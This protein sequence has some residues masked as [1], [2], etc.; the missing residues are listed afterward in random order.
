MDEIKIAKLKKHKISLYWL[1]PIIALIITILL[2]WENS[3]NKGPLILLHMEDAS[4]IE[5]GKTVVKFRSVDVGIVESVNLSDDYSGAV[6]KIR[7]YSDT[8]ELLNED[9]LFWIEKPR[10][11]SH[12]ITGL[13]TIL[14]GC[15]IQIYK[16]KSDKYS[17][18]FVSLKDVP[19]GLNE[20]GIPIKLYGHTTAVI[21]NG[22]QINYKGF[23]IGIIV[24]SSYDIDNDDVVY[25][26][27][28][29]KPYAKLVN[30]N[31][32][33]WV[34]SGVDFSL[35]PSGF[36]FNVPNLENVISGS[37]N[38]YQFSEN[39]GNPLKPNDSFD[40]YKDKI[41][42]K[43]ENLKHNPKYVVLIDDDIK[44]IKVGSKVNFRGLDIG[45][46][47]KMPWYKNDS[48]VFDYKN[49]IPVLIVLDTDKESSLKAEKVFSKNLKDNTLCAQIDNASLITPGNVIKLSIDP[50]NKCRTS[51][52]TYRDVAVIP[53]IK[54]TDMVSEM[55]T[56][57]KK[58]NTLDLKGI[59]NNLNLALLSLDNTL[60][61]V[62]GVTD[63]V[64]SNHTLENLNKVL[65]SYN[66]N[67]D[68]YKSLLDVSNKLNQSLNELNPTIKKVGQKSNSLVFSSQEKDI[69]PKVS[70]R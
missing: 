5:A 32:V 33:F 16:G 30:S 54:K 41:T 59:T 19:L 31:S 9:S 60:K 34:D 49:R 68:L 64:N 65:D 36:N 29:R 39:K 69:E 18:E 28:I 10:I 13:E 2:V 26:A 37:I 67:S 58:L 70:K 6:A 22:S 38:V 21:P 63:S 61:S 20:N 14:S 43:Y 17:T 35:T 47:I 44:N 40:V 42:A 11:Q 50:H 46:V 52:S 24:S 1:V 45:Q 12:S 53:L 51:N 3:F 4:G 48:E 15:Y 27:L 55:Q 25:N 62:K 8:S 7:M 23:N 66:Q 56:L 57:A